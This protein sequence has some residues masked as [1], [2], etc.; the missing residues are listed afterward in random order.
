MTITV[1]LIMSRSVKLILAAMMVLS[2]LSCTKDY[3]EGSPFILFEV[4][5]K[6]V[7]VEGNPIEGIQVS[8][9]TAEVKTTNVNGN[10]SFFGRSA[11]SATASLNFEDKDKEENGGY[12]LNAMKSVPLVLKSPGTS[13]GSYKGTYFAKEVEVVM[14][15]K[16]EGLDPDDGFIGL[17]SLE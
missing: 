15:L 14:I 13:S 11:P 2:A 4:H 9:G 10:F 3:Q 8:S 12:F 6:V 16:E 17:T 5:G 7:D 1:I